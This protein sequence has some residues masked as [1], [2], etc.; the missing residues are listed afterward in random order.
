MIKEGIKTKAQ[1]LLPHAHDDTLS[2]RRRPDVPITAVEASAYTIP[3]DRP[4]G[5]GTLTW[6]STTWVLV[7]R[8][9]PATPH[10]PSGTGLDLRPGRRRRG[11]RATSWPPWSSGRS[12]LDVARSLA[13][14][15]CA[16]SATPVGR[17]WS[18]MA[19]SAVDTALWDLEAR[20]L[21]LP[22]HR[23]FG[24]V[25]DDVPVYGSGGFTT[26]PRGPAARAGRR[27]GRRRASRG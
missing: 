7:T 15:W 12:A 3:T 16:P 26:D 6:D 13:R 2:E 14:R 9:A 11:R 25:R 17:G 24:A 22:L 18:S 23:L 20:L 21:E 8:R 5:D 1:E 10:L 19:I 27:L 4:E